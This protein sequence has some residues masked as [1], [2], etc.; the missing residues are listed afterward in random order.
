MNRSYNPESFDK[1]GFFVIK[2][3]LGKKEVKEVR[4]FLDTLFKENSYPRFL[5]PEIMM[6]IP[7]IYRVKFDKKIIAG[8]KESLGSDFFVS[9]DLRVERNQFVPGW[10]S[11][12]GERAHDPDLFLNE[13][14]IVKVFVS[15]NEHDSGWGGSV[16]FQT[17]G[18]Q[19]YINKNTPRAWYRLISNRVL[20]HVIDYTA[21]VH[22]GDAVVFDP[23]IPHRSS[24][25]KDR[26]AIHEL[27]HGYHYDG[28][29]KEFTKYMIYWHCL[30]SSAKDFHY[31][32]LEIKAIGEESQKRERLIS[33]VLGKEFPHDFQTE[34]VDLVRRSE[35]R[36]PQVENRIKREFFRKMHMEV[37]QNTKNESK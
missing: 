18:H 25:P 19:A 15:L 2:G 27:Q 28:I 33:G 35:V 16:E 29:P 30:S 7:E 3:V 11:D 8:I 10:H 32:H 17:K 34:Y 21:P 12:W 22:A 13:T 9:P 20:R 23:R 1:N 37:Y 36:V 31:K 24:L 26:N 14:K 5:G 4:T 6:Q